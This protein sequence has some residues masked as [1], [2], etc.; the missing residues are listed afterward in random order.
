MRY[1]TVGL[2]SKK[3]NTHKKEKFLF[4]FTPR[5]AHPNAVPVPSTTFSENEQFPNFAAMASEAVA[6]V[7]CTW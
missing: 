5:M 3:K 1:F 6:F 2:F 7:C 4:F